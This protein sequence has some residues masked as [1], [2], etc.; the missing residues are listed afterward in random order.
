MQWRTGI[1]T[2][3]LTGIRA[4]HL[5]GIGAYVLTGIG[6]YDVPQQPIH[7]SPSITPKLQLLETFH[8]SETPQQ[9]RV[10]LIIQ[11]TIHAAEL[12]T[13]KP[14]LTEKP[15]LTK[16]STLDGFLERCTLEEPERCTLEEPQRCTLEK[17]KEGGWE[18][19]RGRVELDRLHRRRGDAEQPKGAR[20]RRKIKTRKRGKDQPELRP[21]R[22]YEAELDVEAQG[23]QRRAAQLRGREDGPQGEIRSGELDVEGGERGGG[24]ERHDDDVRLDAVD[25]DGEMPQPR[26]VREEAQQRGRGLPWAGATVP[27]GDEDLDGLEVR[28]GDGGGAVE[29]RAGP[30]QGYALPSLGTLDQMGSEGGSERVASE[31]ADDMQEARLG[32][33]QIAHDRLVE[34]PARHLDDRPQARG[35][36]CDPAPGRADEGDGELEF[37]D[38]PASFAVS[39]V[40]GGEVDEYLRE[41]FWREAVDG[42]EERAMDRDLG[43]ELAA[44]GA[45]RLNLPQ[46]T[47]Y[48]VVRASGFRI[49]LTRESLH[50]VRLLWSR[51]NSLALHA[52]VRDGL[53]LLEK[54][55]R[56]I[57]RH[58]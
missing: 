54:L 12:Q 37:D 55:C 5:T 46:E 3:D 45:K 4:Y 49:E 27:A 31:M 2:Y 24:A 39:R 34:G 38:V 23:P 16:G 25:L 14:R 21:P 32:A 47:A 7:L 11:A 48:L 9:N 36:V 40:R 10:P 57:K 20:R 43:L 22:F 15:R 6:A 19:G 35:A 28:G 13:A 29:D 41:K 8:P 56:S 18:I 52:E 1:R 44:T 53:G 58:G 51:D 17:P 33:V 42:R 26:G 30:A 50:L